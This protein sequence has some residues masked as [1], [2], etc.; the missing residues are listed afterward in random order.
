MEDTIFFG[1]CV[2]IG[3]APGLIALRFSRAGTGLLVTAIWMSLS[4]VALYAIGLG[5]HGF[6]LLGFLPLWFGGFVSF[7]IILFRFNAEQNARI[8]RIESE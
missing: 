8:D 5:P 1:A 3:A 2:V 6:I 7:A 4:A